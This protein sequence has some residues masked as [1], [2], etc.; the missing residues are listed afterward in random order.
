MTTTPRDTAVAH[1]AV[2]PRSEGMKP[3]PAAAVDGIAALSGALALF[4]AQRH[5]D[6]LRAARSAAALGAP[7]QHCGKL[8]NNIASAL[9]QV[10]RLGQAEAALRDAVALAP[11]T[12]D[13]QANHANVL[14]NLSRIDEAFAAAQAAVAL[15]A[16]P[17]Q[18]AS[19]LNNI[20]L[21]LAVDG[22]LEAAEAAVRT[23][24]G[25]VPQSADILSNHAKILFD[26]G[27][28]DEAF[29]AAQTAAKAGAEPQECASLLNNIALALAADGR[30]EAAEVAVRAAVGLAPQT[31]DIRFNHAKILFDLG[32]CDEAV[33]AARAAATMGAEPRECA[34]LLNNVGVR[35][36]LAGRLLEAEAIFREAISLVPEAAHIHSNLLFTLCYLPGVEPPRLLEEHRA[37]GARFSHP[38]DPLDFPNDPDPTRRIRLGYVS[39]DFREHVV[40]GMMGGVIAHHDRRRFEVFCYAE[41]R[42]PDHV[43]EALRAV[44]DHWRSTVGLSDQEVAAMI[45]ADGID[46]LVDLAGHTAN[47]RLPVFGLKPAP[48]QASWLGYPNTTG[49]PAID[50][51]LVSLPPDR[52]VETPIPGPRPLYTPPEMLPLPPPPCLARGYVTFGCF[53]NA[54]KLNDD[55]IAV[56]A[57]ILKAVPTSR[58][59]LK[60][61]GFAEPHGD[62]WVVQAFAAHGVAPHRIELRGRSSYR[63]YMLE[64]ADIDLSLDPFPY[65]GANTTFDMLHMGV[66]V[67]GL[68]APDPRS[69]ISWLLYWVGLRELVAESREEYARLAIEL[70]NDADRLR[71]LRRALRS[72]LARAGFGDARRLTAELED[73]WRGAW[74]RWTA[75]KRLEASVMPSS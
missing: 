59:V 37:F 17:Q 22:R 45:R 50:Y 57:D 62:N 19:L 11:R 72:R 71:G 52:A 12:A 7:P 41:V 20:A 70:A 18:C 21:A 66:P 25:L 46:V 16:E 51:L 56:W 24:V 32:R 3:A 48:V 23:A 67:V 53:N 35:L 27:R 42:R 55:V 13:I 15:G 28:C 26:L 38:F 61:L 63:Q 31:V 34:N 5:D 44:A 74:E 14:F 54:S 47:N 9:A 60:A 2:A 33:A 4:K 64:T 6:A 36:N 39:P 29:A 73:I 58:L 40:A 49:M 10:G 1:P 65:G 30:L 8:L 69:S 75:A 43:T 68:K